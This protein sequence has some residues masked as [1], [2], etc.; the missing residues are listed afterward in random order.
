MVDAAVL[1]TPPPPALGCRSS[2]A[3]PEYFSSTIGSGA[4]EAEGPALKSLFWYCTT[5]FGKQKKKD[6]VTNRILIF[7]R[8]DRP[9]VGGHIKCAD[10]GVSSSHLAP[11]ASSLPAAGRQACYHS[12]RAGSR[13]LPGP[14]MLLPAR[15]A[16]IKSGTSCGR[17]LRRGWS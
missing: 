17:C 12:C 6:K 16:G 9:D 11:A 13:V 5:V 1:N 10:W 2:T 14:R 7:T 3:E 4:S 15:L 8:Q